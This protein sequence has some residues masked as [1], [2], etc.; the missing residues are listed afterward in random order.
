ML[1]E[2]PKLVDELYSVVRAHPSTMHRFLRNASRDLKEPE[3]AQMTAELL[4]KHPASVEETLIA[5]IDAI[6]KE[7]NARLAM[8]R[9]IARRAEKAVD[10]LTDDAST[11]GRIVAAST[12]IVERKSRAREN[13]LRA[14]REQRHSI[15]AFVKSDPE[16]AKEMTEE[17]L[18]QAVKDKP[19]LEKVLRATG[20]I[21]DDEPPSAKGKR[22]R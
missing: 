16:L 2:E 17:L 15:I 19:A 13:V 18:R 14:A 11:L 22:G 21:D 7:P 1:D 4:A 9:A 5:S 3:L 20:A 6:A 8:D 12:V 10:I